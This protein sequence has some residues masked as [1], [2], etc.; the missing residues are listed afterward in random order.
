MR[1]NKIK[2]LV[3]DDH[4]IVRTGL[5]ALLGR[6]PDIE[7][8]GEASD[9][10]DAVAKAM[11]LNPDVVVLDLVMP[12]KDGV[13]ATAELHAKR[14]DM[15]IL[16]LT[17]FGTSEEITKAFSVGAQGAILKS[18]PNAEL[19]ASIRDIAAGK[20]VVAPEI[21]NMLANDPPVPDLS[22]RQREILES[23]TRGL[24]NNQIA[25]QFD[26]SPESIKTHINKLFKKLGAASRSEAV[27]IALRRHLL[28]I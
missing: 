15:K 21:E 10:N 6:A 25:M 17:S 26:I 18:S 22:P 16:I 14:P 20:R 19:M 13:A 9:G 23:I 8:M 5:V 12:R 4:A 1:T 3:A 28:K 2:V 24:T 27:S 7:V 11:K